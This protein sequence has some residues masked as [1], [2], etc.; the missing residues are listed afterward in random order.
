MNPHENA[1][2]PIDET[3]ILARDAALDVIQ[4]RHPGDVEAQTACA[5]I[6][7]DGLRSGLFVR[8]SNGQS[9]PPRV[10]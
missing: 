7:A 2:H 4:A 1:N 6:A 10:T 3:A 8:V 9:R 5:R